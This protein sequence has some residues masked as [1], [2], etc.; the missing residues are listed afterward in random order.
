MST[1]YYFSD[2]NIENLL[3]SFDAEVKSVQKKYLDMISS[4]SVDPG[5]NVIKER[6]FDSIQESQLFSSPVSLSFD[7]E[8]IE[9]GRA[10]M[11]CFNWHQ[12]NGFNNIESVKTYLEANP[13]VVIKDEYGHVVSFDEFQNRVNSLDK[14]TSKIPLFDQIKSASARAAEPQPTSQAKAKEPSSER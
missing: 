7:Y 6:L 10:T 4:L 1:L 14:S 13:N 8:G 3:D 9:I 2:L 12:N 11:Y 5:M